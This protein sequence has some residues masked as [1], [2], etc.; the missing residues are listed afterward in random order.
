MSE[1]ER[2]P[3][4]PRSEKWPKAD[5]ALLL[6]RTLGDI[7]GRQLLPDGRSWHEIRDMSTVDMLDLTERLLGNPEFLTMIS[8]TDRDELQSLVEQAR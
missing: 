7:I 3:D 5:Q 6:G 1:L 8:V 2:T 4:V